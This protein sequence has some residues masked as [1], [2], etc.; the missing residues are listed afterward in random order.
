M[1]EDVQTHLRTGGYEPIN[2]EMTLRPD[3]KHE[4]E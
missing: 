1:K 3:P 2:E 4:K